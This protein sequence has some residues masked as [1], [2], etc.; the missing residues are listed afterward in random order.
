MAGDIEDVAARDD[1][2]LGS[3]AITDNGSQAA[4]LWNVGGRSEL[5]F[6]ELG[7]LERDP[8]PELPGIS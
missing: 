1:A 2:E 7:T 3:F 4:L 5:E 6:V 8:G